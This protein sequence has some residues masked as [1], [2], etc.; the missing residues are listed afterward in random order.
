MACPESCSI[1][2]IMHDHLGPLLDTCPSPLTTV[3][4]GS[5]EGHVTQAEAIRILPWELFSPE[6][7]ENSPFFS[8]SAALLSRNF[9][10]T[11]STRLWR[12]QPYYD[13]TVSDH[14][15]WNWIEKWTQEGLINSV[16]V[17][18][19]IHKSSEMA[20]APHSSTLVWKIPWTEEPGGLPSMGSHR[21]G[22]DW[23][24]LAA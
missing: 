21:V 18:M 24:D 9:F 4:G 12:E 10:P 23:S 17:Y 3:I 6:L 5:W 15:W 11:I 16:V 2:T 7:E 14:S 8:S 20:M 22:H 19:Y 1:N 13:M